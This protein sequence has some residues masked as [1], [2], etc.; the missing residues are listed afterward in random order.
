MIILMATIINN[1]NYNYYN[2][3]KKSLFQGL[4][5]MYNEIYN[6]IFFIYVD[7]NKILIYKYI[8]NIFA[9]EKKHKVYLKSC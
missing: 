2:G 7:N 5:S 3:K 1:N 6:S 8:A 4:K 9:K